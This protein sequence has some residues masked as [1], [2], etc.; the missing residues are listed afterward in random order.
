MKNLKILSVLGIFGLTLL[1]TGCGT[2]KSK[3]L[4]EPLTNIMT[5]IYSNI[6]E[7]KIPMALA[8]TE[9][10]SENLEGYTG[11]KS[12]DFESGLASESMVGSIAHSVVLLR[13]KDGAD[14]EKIKSDI[15]TNVNPRKWICVGVDDEKNIIVDNIGN[16][17]ILI[18]DN[19]IAQDLHNNFKA[20][21][22]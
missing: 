20:L 7:E 13:V 12:L 1:L 6:N 16:T 2:T 9:I 19:E 8:N 18:M 11:L 14:I 4:T 5:S 15:K 22:K 17:I 21:N 10:T 3:N